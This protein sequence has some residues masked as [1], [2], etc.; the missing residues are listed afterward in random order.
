ML[1]ELRHSLLLDHQAAG[2][3]S[4]SSAYGSRML[5]AFQPRV[6]PEHPSHPHDLVLVSLG[7]ELWRRND[8][9]PHPWPFSQRDEKHIPPTIGWEFVM[10]RTAPSETL[11]RHALAMTILLR[12][13]RIIRMFLARRKSGDGANAVC[14]VVG[15]ATWSAPIHSTRFPRCEMPLPNE[16]DLR[17]KV[18]PP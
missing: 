7:L 2:K 3:C 11:R 6:P 17:W 4:A 1:S 18:R 5:P 14:R 9:Q 16:Q 12:V 8:S 10:L 15:R 13:W